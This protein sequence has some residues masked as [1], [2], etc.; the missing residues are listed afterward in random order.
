MLKIRKMVVMDVL[1]LIA[2][3]RIHRVNG[4]IA[5]E[6]AGKVG[7]LGRAGAG[8]CC[9]LMLMASVSPSVRWSGSVGGLH[10]VRIRG[11]DREACIQ[12]G[13]P[14]VKSVRE[15]VVV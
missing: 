9:G 8:A 6:A 10:L 14:V 3:R 13:N 5:T 7:V 11:G 15:G 2:A 1:S 12:M 4:S